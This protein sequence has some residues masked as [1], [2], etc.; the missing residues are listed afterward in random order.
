MLISLY[1]PLTQELLP[2]NKR[3]K[4]KHFC[5]RY[6][7]REIVCNM[8]FKPH[9]KIEKWFSSKGYTPL[10]FQLMAWEAYNAGKSGVINAPTGSGKTMAI[11]MGVMHEQLSSPLKPTQG[12]KILY[13][14]PLRSLS[15]DLLK[16]ITEATQELGVDMRIELRTGDTN[17]A[18]RAKQKK[19]MPQCLITTPE[20]LHLLICQNG[21]AQVFSGLQAVIVDEWHDLL[22]SKRGTQVELALAYLKTVVLPPN[23]PLKIWGI[24]ATIANLP[25]ALEVLLGNSFEPTNAKIIK[26][27]IDKKIRIETLYPDT[28]ERF[29]WGGRVGLSLLNKVLEVV[30]ASNSTLI[31]TNTRAQTEIWYQNLLLYGNHLAGN[32]AIHHSSLEMEIRTWVEDA[33]KQNKLKAV[34]C[35]SSLDLGVDFAPVET[36]IQIGSPKDVSRIMQRAGRSGHRPGHESVVYFVPTHSLELIDAAAIKHALTK[37]ELEGRSPVHKP[38]DVLV[39]FLV[40]LA[41]GDGFDE[42]LAYRMVKSTYAYKQLTDEEWAWCLDYITSGGKSLGAYDEFSK[43]LQD[44]TGRYVVTNRKIALQHKLS[45]GTIVGNASIR[46]KLLNGG[47]VG[48]VEEIFFAKMKEGDV[49]WFGG[50]PLAFVRIKDM[51]AYVRVATS[52]KGKTPAWGGGR[53]PLSSTFAHLLRECIHAMAS[54]HFDQQELQFIRPLA[55]LQMEWSALPAADELLIEYFKTREGYH[56]VVYPFEGRA[57]HELMASLLAYRISQYMEISFSMGM[58]DYGFELLSDQQID[59]EELLSYDLF[60]TQNLQKD[61]ES[62]INEAEMARRKFRDIATIAGLVFTG[63]PGK[64]ASGKHLQSNSQLIYDVLEKYDP[65]NLLLRQA[66]EEVLEYQMENSRLQ[67]T[68]ERIQQQKIT[69]KFPKRITPFAFPILVD[70]LR[71][72]LTSESLEARITKM[73][74]QLEKAATK[75]VKKAKTTV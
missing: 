61:V 57:I 19:S 73:T 51:T 5:C 18:Q 46:V 56:L 34:V 66:H 42:Q 68:L 69:L 67:S 11:W 9:I 55:E 45:I 43:V 58:N 23:R 10:P 52:G 59:V 17:S 31:F 32:M 27:D 33:L 65:E 1:L 47:Y 53:M 13:I 8:S 35:T 63:Y 2:T 49:F 21:A 38:I 44:D 40:T 4:A 15:K 60:S 3:F 75:P 25:Q 7:F 36:I 48:T 26:A 22:S 37:N 39:Q 50:R 64:P 41:V 54:G 6:A 74:L 62:S 12:L 71:E 20:S 14:S 29:P 24:S 28:I 72:K 30:N 70:M 16:N